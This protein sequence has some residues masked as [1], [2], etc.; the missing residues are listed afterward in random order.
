[1]TVWVRKSFAESS[2]EQETLTLAFKAFS[3][4]SR[5]ALR[6]STGRVRA[7]VIGD[8]FRRL[9]GRTLA[10]LYA[11]ALQRATLPFQFGLSTRAGTEAVHR[12]LQVATE[13]DP[14]A[15]ILSLD[16]VGAFDHVSRGIGEVGHS[17]YDWVMTYTCFFEF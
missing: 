11:P 17:G 13:L 7:L 16:A 1:M 10:R 12:C 15:T 2:M 14:Q 9:V 8:T 4:V 3:P 5:V 6:K